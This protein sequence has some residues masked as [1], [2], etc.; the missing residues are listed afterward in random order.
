MYIMHY[1]TTSYIVKLFFYICKQDNIQQ[2][3][4][5]FP[6]RVNVLTSAGAV[7]LFSN[8]GKPNEFRAAFF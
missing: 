8:P 5:L 3:D 7:A 1:K 6:K 2:N 4:N